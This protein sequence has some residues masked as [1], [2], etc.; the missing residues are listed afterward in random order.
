MAGHF[1]TATIA[2][3]V[4]E[5]A[6]RFWLRDKP[7]EYPCGWRRQPELLFAFHSLPESSRHSGFLLRCAVLIDI[8]PDQ[9]ADDLGRR[10]VIQRAN[11]FQN[12]LLDWI[13]QYR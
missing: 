3:A 7:E 5:M 2:R 13:N 11:L 6:F 10:E 9:A 1:L 8:F 12:L 4:Q